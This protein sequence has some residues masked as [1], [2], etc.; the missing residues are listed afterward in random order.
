MS[1][2][3]L[4]TVTISCH[5]FNWSLSAVTLSAEDSCDTT[6]MFQ[7]LSVSIQHLTLF[8][9]LAALNVL[10]TVINFIL[11]NLTLTFS[12]YM[13]TYDGIM[14]DNVRVRVSIYVFMC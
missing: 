5:S 4:S 9:F 14:L 7:R 11:S 6:Y 12:Y 1:A 2:A 13:L 8:A 3:A 10:L